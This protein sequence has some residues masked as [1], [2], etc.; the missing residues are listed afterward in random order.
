MFVEIAELRGF[1]VIG[2]RD[3]DVFDVTLE[4]RCICWR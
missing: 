2:C 4:A 1:V 3:S